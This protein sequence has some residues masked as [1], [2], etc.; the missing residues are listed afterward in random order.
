MSKVLKTKYGRARI[1]PDGY[2]RITSRREGNCGKLLHKLVWI[3]HNGPIP[4]GDYVV[5]HIDENPLNND[6]NNLELMSRSEHTI[7]HHKGSTRSDKTCKN[8]SK[9]LAGRTLSEEH[10]QKLREANIG[11]KCYNWRGEARVVKGGIEPY[12]RK[13]RYLLI[14]KNGKRIKYSIHKEKLLKEMKE[15]N[16]KYG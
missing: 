7:H 16:S 1:Q 14:D 15:L 12:N 8:I 2:Y 9:G 3:D 11:E 4:D 13:Q 10:R 6:I 5:H